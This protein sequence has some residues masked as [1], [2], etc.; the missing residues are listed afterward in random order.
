[1][2]SLLHNNITLIFEQQKRKKLHYSYLQ[3]ARNKTVN[4][5]VSEMN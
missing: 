4:V 1:M 2:H 5:W 3:L